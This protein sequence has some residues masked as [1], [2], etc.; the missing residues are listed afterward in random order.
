MD[1]KAL[2]TKNGL[3]I[4]GCIL[5]ALVFLGIAIKVVG[6]DVGAASRRKYAGHGEAANLVP[7][8][9][10]SPS[11]TPMQNLLPSGNTADSEA[12]EKA[13]IPG[14]L[15][16]EAT[17]TPTPTPTPTQEVSSIPVP[18]GLVEQQIPLSRQS[19][20]GTYSEMNPKVETAPS[21]YLFDNETPGAMAGGVTTITDTNG[22]SS[23]TFSPVGESISLRTMASASTR[24][25][26]IPIV[27]GVWEPFYFNGHKLLDIGDKIVGT[28]AAG[29]VQGKATVTFHK[30][31][32]KDGKSM[33]INAIGTDVAGNLGI[34][35]VTVGNTLMSAIGPVLL[36]LASAVTKSFEQSATQVTGTGAV[37]ATASGLTGGLIGG[38]TVSAT[39]NATQS[40]Q[41]AGLQ[42]AQAALD[43]I[44]G[45][46]ATD[47][48]ENKPYLLV[49]PGTACK[50]LLV[51]PLDVSRR[52]LG[53]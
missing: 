16:D 27:A 24:D 12:R 2:L 20:S 43:K 35:G 41:N 11:G 23:K 17:P 51:E 26:E 4:G 22:I 42:G 14:V 10:P 33:T 52:G 30:I 6:S 7:Q 31:I 47:M 36:S 44:S 40:A 18:N 25:T 37:A 34:P 39:Q 32:F 29:K 5:M 13:V 3:I 8:P 19:G 1:Y 46:L 53:Q 15:K 38:Q 50:A 9:T 21:R 48:E 49:L 28:A 45:L